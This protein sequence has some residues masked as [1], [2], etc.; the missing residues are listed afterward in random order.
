MCRCTDIM[1]F[2]NPP[3]RASRQ[4]LIPRIAAVGISLSPLHAYQRPP[5]G[6]RD[7][8]RRACERTPLRGHRRCAACGRRGDTTLT[9]PLFDYNLMLNTNSHTSS[10]RSLHLHFHLHRRQRQTQ[11]NVCVSAVSFHKTDSH[12]VR[13]DEKANKLNEFTMDQYRNGKSRYRFENSQRITIV[14]GQPP[15][16]EH[17][18]MLATYQ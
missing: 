2:Q 17:H 13:S 18:I 12:I 3:Y 15:F 8:C 14:F 4:L 6:G 7:R 9:I 1:F 16:A 11:Q 5:R 10:H